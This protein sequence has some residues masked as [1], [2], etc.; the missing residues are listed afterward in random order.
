MDIVKVHIGI[1][2]GAG[3]CVAHVV[4]ISEAAVAVHSKAALTSQ[5]CLPPKA[6]AHGHHK[7][8]VRNTHTAS[9]PPRPTES[10]LHV[11]KIPWVSLCT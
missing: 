5:T 6:W 3:G 7:R 8:A 1:A 9:G 2:E 10:Q 11:R 4:G